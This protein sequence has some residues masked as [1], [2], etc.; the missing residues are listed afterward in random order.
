MN[1]KINGRNIKEDTLPE[2]LINLVI[3][4]YHNRLSRFLNPY[5]YIYSVQ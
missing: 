2:D 5:L 1:T 4:R 3:A